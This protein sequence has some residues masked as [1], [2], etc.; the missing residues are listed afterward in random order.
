MTDLLT[1]VPEAH[2]DAVVSAIESAFARGPETALEPVLG[3]AS[4]ALAYRTNVA[5]SPRL[6]R[7]ET[8]RSWRNPAQDEAM[9]EAARVGI[10]PP[11]HWSDPVAGIV[12]MDFI[13]SRPLQEFPGGPAALAQAAGALIRRMQTETVFP[14]VAR[15]PEVIGTL[16]GNARDSGMFAAGLLDSHF[17]G[18]ER[19]C[20]AYP[21]DDDARVASHNDPNP[22]NWL[23][24]GQRLWLVDW[25]TA[26]RNEPLVDVAILTHEIAPTPDLETALL[27]GWRG[28][29]PD[30][31]LRARVAVMR[32]LTRLYYAGLMLSA[33]PREV[34]LPPE[35]SLDAPDVATF[36]QQV[37]SGRLRIGSPEMIFTL[38]KMNLAG[39]LAAISDADFQRALDHVQR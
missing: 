14:I 12:V 2:R 7:I 23:F 9:A 26:F 5:G 13:A 27:I 21:W 33:H 16:L 38:A 24:D 3:G 1:A 20:A 37:M 25:E 8:R 39:F 34:G 28:A 4:G 19:I 18:F 32:Q 15:Y 30:D 17:A 10:A 29:P 22:R 31:A 6:L 36:Q 35:T 11:L